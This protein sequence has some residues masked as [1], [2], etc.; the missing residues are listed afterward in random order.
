MRRL[1]WK[2]L[3]CCLAATIL[4]GCQA[5]KSILLED[6]LCEPP[7]WQNIMP[8]SSSREEVYQ[9]VSGLSFI[10]TAPLATPKRNDNSRS[11]D[12]WNFQENIRERGG[13]ITYSN[14]IVA[15][16]EFS[17][18]GN[19]R[20]GKMIDFYGKPKFISIIT[21]WE[22]SRWLEVM[23]IYPTRGIVIIH[24]NHNWRPQGDYANITPDLPVNDVYYFDPDL[25]DTLVETVF[26]SP[27]MRE[28]V[29]ESTRPW[30]DYGPMPY[31]EE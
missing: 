7:C 27:T 25:Y 21:G 23:W 10:H 16:M 9:I 13:R 28:V 15:Y 17:E 22:D 14:N 18:S 2:L 29:Q 6:T 19:I 4:G 24:F 8:G 20:I 3:F 30:I 11:Y 26:Y 12:S 31:T 5:K 1:I